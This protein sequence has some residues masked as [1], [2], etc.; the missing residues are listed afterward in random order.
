MQPPD[1]NMQTWPIERGNSPQGLK[2]ARIDTSRG[3]LMVA[4]ADALSDVDL[5]MM[6]GIF[7]SAYDPTLKAHKPAGPGPAIPTGL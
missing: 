7:V 6:A 1:S 2:V 5:R 4:P 3:W